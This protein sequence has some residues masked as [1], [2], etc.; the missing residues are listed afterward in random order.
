[1]EMTTIEEQLLQSKSFLNWTPEPKTNKPHTI[2][3]KRGQYVITGTV[4]SPFPTSAVRSPFP[5]L[6]A[7]DSATPYQNLIVDEKHFAP[8]DLAKAWGLSAEKVRQLFRSEPGVL[9]IGN[10]GDKHDRGYVTLRIPQ[11]VAVRVHT[12]LTAVPQ[13]R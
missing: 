9:R 12:R 3:V 2:K 7:V 5:T 6:D 8:A 11:S 13:T 10:S 1:M 4:G